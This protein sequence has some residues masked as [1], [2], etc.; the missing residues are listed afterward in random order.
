MEA[1]VTPN[2]T[3]NVVAKHSRHLKFFVENSRWDEENN[4]LRIK[5]F[6]NLKN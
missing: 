6:Y 2:V 5:I 4:H 3:P 1:N